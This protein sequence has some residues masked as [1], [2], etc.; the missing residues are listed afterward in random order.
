MLFV[1]GYTPDPLTLYRRE[2]PDTA[3]LQK[4]F[5]AE[6]LVTAVRTMLSPG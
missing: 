5:D 1:S 3:F 6:Q 4:P 2:N